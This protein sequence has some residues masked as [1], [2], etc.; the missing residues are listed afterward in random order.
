MGLFL[1]LGAKVLFLE[2]KKMNNEASML[3]GAKIVCFGQIW[4]RVNDSNAPP[5]L[6][7]NTQNWAPTRSATQ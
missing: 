6:S 2:K 4:V 3:F 5:N 7:F 1:I